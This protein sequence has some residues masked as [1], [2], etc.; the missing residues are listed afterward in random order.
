MADVTNH[1]TGRTS[2]FR[3][4]NAHFAVLLIVAGAVIASSIHVPVAKIAASLQIHTAPIVDT[5]RSNG[6]LDETRPQVQ[7]VNRDSLNRQVV[8]MA[9]TSTPLPTPVPAT[10]VPPTATLSPEVANSLAPLFTPE[11][12]YWKDQSLRWSLAT[13]LNPNL[14]ATVI[15]IESCGN[16]HIVSPA[17]AQGLFQV[18]PFFFKPGEDPKDPDTNAQHGLY[19]L[20]EDLALAHGDVGLALAS[21]NGGPKILRK[22]WR[23]WMHETHLYY[24]WGSGIYG[25]ASVGAS[26]SSTLDYWLNVSNGDGLCQMAHRELWGDGAQEA[27]VPPTVT[28]MAQAQGQA[29]EQAPEASKPADPQQEAQPKSRAAGKSPVIAGPSGQP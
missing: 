19:I 26:R 6:L 17:G 15:Q 24:Q 21:Y 25:D 3:R 28:A 22:A 8:L 2:S 29:Q 4:F 20:K 14:I 9:P 23:Y 5:T 7:P 18:M 27:A 13:G 10:V 12:Q 1:G 11:V 16:P